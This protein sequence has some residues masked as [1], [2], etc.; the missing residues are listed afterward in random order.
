MIDLKLLYQLYIQEATVRINAL[1]DKILDLESSRVKIIE[2][3]NK[4]ELYFRQNYPIALSEV[5]EYIEVDKF[6]PNKEFDPMLAIYVKKVID[7]NAQILNTKPLIDEIK[8][9]IIPLDVFTFVIYR[10]NEKL[11]NKVVDTNYIIDFGR[12][13]RLMVVKVETDRRRVNWG[14]SNKNKAAIIKNGKTPYYKKDAEA[15]EKAGIEY[16]GVEWLV[17]MPSLDFIFY[18]AVPKSSKKYIPIITDYTFKPLMGK[19]S[20]VAKLAKVKKNL[21]E[22]NLR[23]TISSNSLMRV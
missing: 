2:F 4:K 21:D 11:I 8:K 3:I 13:G 14:Q 10:F 9:S 5:L 12:L 22:A 7:I 19:T 17:L 18:W 16:D 6:E 20:P 1:S 15:A 23:Y